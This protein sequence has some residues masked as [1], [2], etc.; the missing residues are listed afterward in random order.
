MGHFF[1]ASA[2]RG[3]SLGRLVEPVAAYLSGHGLKCSEVTGHPVNEATD[4]LFYDPVQGWATVVWP[5][6]FNIHDVPLC[7]AVSEALSCAALTV[8]VYDGDFW[9]WETLVE[10][11]LVDQCAPRADYFAEDDGAAER[12]RARWRGQ[13]SLLAEVAGVPVESVAPYYRELGP[14]DAPGK[15]FPDDQFPLDDFWVFT[16][17]WRRL[18]VT[19]PADPD[20]FAHRL[21]LPRDFASR[22]PTWEGGGD[23]E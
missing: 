13:P 20:S 1:A 19:Y 18:G 23:A 16:D 17:L 12:A 5:T 3:P 21:R 9:S 10:G 6:Y 7:A 4:V 15:A 14:E 8:N 2:F 22:L 11:I